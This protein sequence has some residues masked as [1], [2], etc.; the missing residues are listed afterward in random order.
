MKDI[1][2]KGNKHIISSLI[3]AYNKGYKNIIA[4]THVPPF[5][6]SSL[7]NNKPSNDTWAPFFTNKDLGDNLLKF[8]YEHKDCKITVLCGHTHHRALYQPLNNLVVKT[9]DA[10]YHHPKIEEI[11][12]F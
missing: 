9:G 2:I 5:L 11:L 4:L 12:L 3:K 6:Q 8:A 1:S 10:E 7:Y